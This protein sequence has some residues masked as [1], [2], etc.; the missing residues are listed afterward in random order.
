MVALTDWSCAVCGFEVWGVEGPEPVWSEMT[1]AHECDAPFN[2]PRWVSDH[3]PIWGVTAVHT[4]RPNYCAAR[5]QRVTDHV[6]YS[7][8]DCVEVTCPHCGDA[9]NPSTGCRK[10]VCIVS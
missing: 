6:H 1:N 9:V 5:G 8:G 2:S 3:E 7:N 10:I 4:E